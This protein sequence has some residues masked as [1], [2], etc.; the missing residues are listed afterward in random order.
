[1][2][3]CISKLVYMLHQVSF[4][5]ILIVAHDQQSFLVNDIIN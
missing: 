2:I 1:M 5:V 3:G 4:D